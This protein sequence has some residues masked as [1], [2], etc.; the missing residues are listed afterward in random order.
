MRCIASVALGHYPVAPR[1]VWYEVRMEPQ[2]HP[3]VL[4][5]AA[6]RSIRLDAI[7]AAV[8]DTI[9]GLHELDAVELLGR[10]LSTLERSPDSSPLRE[11]LATCCDELREECGMPTE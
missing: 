6:W 3:T 2:R 1:Q 4:L 5:R 8:Q 9:R 11:A 10:E 7:R